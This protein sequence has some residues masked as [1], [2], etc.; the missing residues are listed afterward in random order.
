MTL[1]RRKV[2]ESGR[3][4]PYLIQTLQLHTGDLSKHNEAPA[5]E[6]AGAQGCGTMDD[7]Q[8]GMLLTDRYKN[9]DRCGMLLDERYRVGRKLSEG[10][11]SAVYSVTDLQSS[12][13][14]GARRTH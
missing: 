14:L 1:R 11:F 4:Q 9:D 13:A 3:R 2:L 7:V 8:R 12:R 5:V 6:G 10:S